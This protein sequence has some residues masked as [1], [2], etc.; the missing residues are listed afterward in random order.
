[1]QFLQWAR[2]SLPM[3][4]MSAV[5]DRLR[6]RLGAA[7]QPSHHLQSWGT[8]PSSV[9]SG[10]LVAL[11]LA[12]ARL[13]WHRT[14][15]PSALSRR[16]RRRSYLGAVLAESKRQEVRRLD[17]FAPRLLPASGNGGTAKIQAAWKQINLRERVRVLTLDLEECLQAGTE[18]LDM[19]IEVRVLPHRRDL[20]SDGLTFH[21]FDTPVSDEAIAI[22]NHHHG[23]ADRPV[24]IK[25]VASTEVFRARFRTEWE[26]AR[27]LESV[28][29]ERIH[30]R[31]APC[32]GTTS[33][34]RSVEEAKEKGLHLGERST[35][36][37]LPHLAF[38][39]SCAVVFILGLPGSGKSYVRSRLAQHLSKMRIESQ[40]LTDYPYAYVDLMRT[41]LK[42]DPA[43]GNEFQAYDGGAFGVENEKSLAPA[44]R[45]LHSDVRDA[46]QAREVTLVEFARADL[47]AALQTFDDIRSRSHVV[48]VRAPTNLRQTRLADRVVPPEVRIDG[49]AVTLTLSDDH[50]LPDCVEQMLYVTDGLDRIKASA[51]WRDRIFE[52]DNEFEGITHVD[53][54]ISE[55]IETV[56]NPYRPAGS[57]VSGCGHLTPAFA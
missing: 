3:G 8:V 36:R 49:Q 1:M 10:I 56:V 26:K 57:N 44:L 11:I 12:T 2:P 51:L 9:V 13:V 15:V 43:S 46:L 50:L 27:P 55:F 39:D 24:R 45:A 23:D 32:Q 25:G 20:G 17:V 21:L 18:L 31:S 42:L 34:L 52:I 7:P 5:A 22:I 16:V 30:P 48:Y 6:L 35:Q 14:R 38:Q 33:V 29:A 4:T 47:A 53:A 54:K 40:S 41:V 19:D 28:V 37:I